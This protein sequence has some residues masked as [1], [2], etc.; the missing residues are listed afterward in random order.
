M[1]TTKNEGGKRKDVVSQRA[2][3]QIGRV[4]MQN[5]TVDDPIDGEMTLLR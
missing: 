4:E 2:M 3:I 1:K 5:L